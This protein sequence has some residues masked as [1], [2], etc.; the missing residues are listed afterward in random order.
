MGESVMNVSVVVPV[1]NGSRYIIRCLES[2]LRQL[3]NTMELIVVDDASTD[4]TFDLLLRTYKNDKR[5]IFVRNTENR[6]VAAARNTGIQLARGLF[7]GFCDADDEWRGDKLEKQLAYIH[8]HPETQIVYAGC[9]TVQDEKTERTERLFGYA[10]ADTLHLR[11]AVIRKDVFGKIGLLDETVR[12]REDTEWMVRARTSGCISAFL[13]QPLYIRHIQSDGLSAKAGE[14]GRKQ[15]VISAFIR[16][17]RRKRLAREYPYDVSILI[18]VFN[19]EKYIGEAIKSCV[20]EKYSCQLI[21]VD[22]GSE[23][24][25]VSVIRALVEGAGAAGTSRL[26]EDR[27]VKMSV[28][29]VIRSHKGQAFS[30]NDAF[31]CARG[32]YLLYLD[33]DDYCMQGAV[34]RMMDEAVSHPDAMLVSALCRDF[35]SPELTCAEASKLRI[36]PEPYR[37]ML[38]GCMLIR[39]ELF[40]IVGVHDESMATSET[41]QW[42]MKVRDSGIK[43]HETDYVVL[44]RR[45]HKE[46]LGRVNRKA[47][48]SSY[49]AMIR[50]RLKRKNRDVEAFGHGYNE[51]GDILNEIFKG[52]FL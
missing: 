39:R 45:Y 26:P 13:N 18:P 24:Q 23:D 44:A 8:L 22:D 21:I 41:A 5:I 35:I 46:N 38:A 40:D 50:G 20:S 27:N 14:A 48:M 19:A 10:E 31:R 36:N 28:T 51:N 47:Q 7:I 33:A 6:G 43:I 52:R 11:T 17:I 32:K 37:R 16:G 49:M 15:R 34:D 9:E 42:V 29:C 1:Y 25:S 4:G 12:I 30:R 2:I 3:D